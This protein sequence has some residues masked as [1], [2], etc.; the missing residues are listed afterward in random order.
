[1]QTNELIAVMTAGHRPVDTGWLRRA[2]W[3]CALA[4]LALTALLVL[5][6]LGVRPDLAG[7]WST[8]PVIA[9][10]LVGA[11]VAGIALVL[12]QRSL[13][14]GLKPG[15]ELPL[16]ALPVALIALWALAALFQAPFADWSALIF[17]RYWRACLVA[18]PL[19]ALVPLVVLFGLARRGA[20][21]DGRL[22]GAC[23]GLASA[24]LATLAY[25][26]HCPDDTAPFLATWYTIAIAAVTG[27]GALIFPRLLRW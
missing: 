19:Y 23:A 20:P 24:G 8:P 26:L 4:A 9:K 2:T 13:R 15:R 12:F 1:M 14:P 16:V 18:V 27:I 11:S 17:G 22:T 3:L 21:V 7:V 25:S 5:I 6:V 10:A